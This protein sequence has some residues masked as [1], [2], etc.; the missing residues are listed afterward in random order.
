VKYKNLTTNSVLPGSVLAGLHKD[1]R[2]SWVALFRYTNSDA[3]DVVTFGRGISAR[4]SNKA[5]DGYTVDISSP[6]GN[7]KPD[8]GICH[9]KADMPDGLSVM[10]TGDERC[11]N[12]LHYSNGLAIG[13]WLEWERLD[14]GLSLEAEFKTPYDIKKHLIAPGM[15]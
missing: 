1:A 6:G 4:Y 13:K 10:I 12:W 9:L 2:G 7:A 5:K 3:Q 8:M 14:N 11:L 15:N